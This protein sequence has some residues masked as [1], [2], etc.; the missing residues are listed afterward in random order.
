[1]GV[2]GQVLDPECPRHPGR[3]A[4]RGGNVV[5]LEI[6]E[7]LEAVV[8][9]GADGVGPGRG[10]ELQPDLGH[11]EPG[12]ELTGQAH[13]LDQI[14]DIEGQGHLGPQLRGE[15]FR[16]LL[17]GLGHDAFSW[18]SVSLNVRFT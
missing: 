11:P 17:G 14:V 9:H 7:D 13:G 5:Q 1:M 18:M 2:H 16:C 3:L 12:G 10:V 4:D 15:P 6:E 8:E